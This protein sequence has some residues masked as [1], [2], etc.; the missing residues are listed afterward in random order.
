M[1]ERDL[2]TAGRVETDHD[3]LYGY[4]FETR[5][6][7]GLRSVGHSGGAIGMNAMFEMFPDMGYVV[8]VLANRDPPAA[9]RVAGLIREG[10]EKLKQN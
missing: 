2:V 4:G 7:N 5:T 10:L 3:S 1:T 8:V 9:G 6:V